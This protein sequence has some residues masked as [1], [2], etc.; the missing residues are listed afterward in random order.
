MN[1]S[2]ICTCVRSS[3]RARKSKLNLLQSYHGFARSVTQHRFLW[4]LST[5]SSIRARSNLNNRWSGFASEHRLAIY[6]SIV[7]TAWADGIV[8]KDEQAI[9]DDMSMYLGWN[10]IKLNLSKSK[11]EMMQS[12]QMPKTVHC[13][14]KCSRWLGKMAKLIR[15]SRPCWIHSQTCSD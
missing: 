6:E 1:S 10:H 15:M 3:L 14:S 4:N 9:L 8:T 12:N 7:R 13:T 5:A 11:Q 2:R